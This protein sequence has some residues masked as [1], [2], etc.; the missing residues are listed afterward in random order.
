MSETIEFFL[1]DFH[2]IRW[3]KNSMV[4]RDTTYLTTDAFLD[5]VEKDNSITASGMVSIHSGDSQWISNQ[6]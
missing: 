1:N 4:T 2:W 3:I 6:R 5:V